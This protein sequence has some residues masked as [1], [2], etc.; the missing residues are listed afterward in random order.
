MHSSPRYDLN[1]NR[2]KKYMLTEKPEL[3]E[4]IPALVS[5]GKYFFMRKKTIF[6]GQNDSLIN[7]CPT[8]I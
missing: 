1:E 2:E 6:W 8:N 4:Q 3:W 5:N 7:K